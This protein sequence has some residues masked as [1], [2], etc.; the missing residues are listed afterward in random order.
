VRIG[1]RQLSWSAEL[2]TGQT[3]SDEKPLSFIIGFLNPLEGD[4]QQERVHEL[5]KLAS[6]QSL[7]I[8]ILRTSTFLPH[9]QRPV[10]IDGATV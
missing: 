10:R 5:E 6:K 7:E 4:P 8:E 9:K 1:Y 3:G 2:H